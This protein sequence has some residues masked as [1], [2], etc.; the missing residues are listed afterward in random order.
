MAKKK[1]KADKAAPRVVREVE[2]I[3]EA[4]VPDDAPQTAAASKEEVPPAKPRSQAKKTDAAKRAAEDTP[5]MVRM[6]TLYLAV[7]VALAVGL[8]LG[9]LLP[10]LMAGTPRTEAAQSVA[11]QAQPNAQTAETERL[12]GEILATEEVVRKNPQDAEA[13][14]R[15]GNLYFDT[16]K[17]MSA[18]GAYER[19]LL[20]K[21][22]NANVLTDLGIMYREAGK[23]DMAVESFRKAVRVNPK[24]QNA[25][26]NTGVVLFFD[27]GRKD[28]ARKAWQQLLDVNP[29]AAAPDGKPV[30]DLLRELR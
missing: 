23:Y 20:I 13:L 26:F 7:G 24:H 21:P 28:D 14:V 12:T 29:Q 9:T 22:D 10:S 11:P 5:G 27:L 2:E 3:L 16:G 4:A 30:K 18:I 17:P 19:A 1:R 8:Y 25:L 15:L 6:S